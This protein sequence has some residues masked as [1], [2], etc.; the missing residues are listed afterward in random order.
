MA[1][2]LA[3]L[4][5]LRPA[6]PGGPGAPGPL[7]TSKGSQNLGKQIHIP[8]RYANWLFI[9]VLT[10]LS[11]GPSASLHHLVMFC[12]ISKVYVWW[13]LVCLGYDSGP[14]YGQGPPA[15]IWPKSRG[16]RVS[17]LIVKSKYL[18]NV[19]DAVIVKMLRKM[20]V[21]I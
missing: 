12:F 5:G 4:W 9:N 1:T 3:A 16:T 8:L 10:M 15:L 7:Q 21:H 11:K 13:I 18:E 14:L 20:I 6:A 19:C 17:K 2:P